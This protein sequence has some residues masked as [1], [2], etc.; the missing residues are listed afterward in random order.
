MRGGRMGTRTRRERSEDEEESETEEEREDEEERE[1]REKEGGED[2]IKKK[3]GVEEGTRTRVNW[4]GEEGMRGGR[5]EK[6]NPFP[7]VSLLCFPEFT[8][9]LISENILF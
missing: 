2:R 7:L 9:V 4:R 6:E 5:V 3:G 1:E 8:I